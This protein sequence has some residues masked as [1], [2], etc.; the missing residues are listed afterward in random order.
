MLVLFA[1][2]VATILIDS[3]LGV[4]SDSSNDCINLLFIVTYHYTLISGCSVKSS[5]EFA[6]NQYFG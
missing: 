1:I 5:F 6:I 3:E 2:V 4:V